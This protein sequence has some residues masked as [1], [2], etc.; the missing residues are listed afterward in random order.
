MG[1]EKTENGDVKV[2]LLTERVMRMC[3]QTGYT[4]DSVF[5]GLIDYIIGYL[6]P[7]FSPQPVEEWKFTKEDSLCFHDMMTIVIGIYA[8]EIERSGWYDPFGDLYMSLHANGGGKGQFFT[9]ASLCTMTA[10]VCCG[11]WQEPEGQRTPF[12]RRITISDCAAG[13]GRMPLAGYCVLLR[14]MQKEWGYTPAEAEAKRPYLVCEDLDYN[15]VKMSAINMAFHGCF[16]EAV[17]HDTLSEPDKVRLGYII[18]ET[19]WPFPTNVPSIRKETR[20]ECFVATRL[21]TKRKEHGG[22]V[23]IGDAQASDNRVE[24]DTVAKPSHRSNIQRQS[25]DRIN[26]TA[27]YHSGGGADVKKNEPQQLTLW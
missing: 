13:S 15:C 5:S 10:E 17:C 6:N 20:P 11:D 12:G 14:K 23:G 21:W 18:N 9:P 8:H 25:T 26:A 7:S 3:Q 22:G 24:M 4:P 1:K 19:M 16:G 2:R 27:S